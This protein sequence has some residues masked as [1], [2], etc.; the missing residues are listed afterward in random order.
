MGPA[1]TLKK[2]VLTAAPHTSNW[3]FPLMIATTR[4]FGVKVSWIGKHTLFKGPLGWFLRATGGIG[5]NRSSPQNLVSQMVDAF[6]RAD[7]LVV[8]VPP[9]GTRSRA[10]YW[11]SGFYHMARS[12]GV[13]LVL[14]YID[15]HKKECGFGPTIWPSGNLRADMDQIRDFF[16]QKQ[17]LYPD[18]FG[19]IRLRD[20]DAP[21]PEIDA[22]RLRT[23]AA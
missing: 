18:R 12:A 19:P 9:E 15:A 23:G 10:P 6:D 5:V 4:H 13:P 8:C 17:P 2:Y 11:K 7:E 3:D 20:E 1:P 14:G 22:S 16:A 21:M